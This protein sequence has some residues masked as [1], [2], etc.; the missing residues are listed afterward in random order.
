MKKR[1]SMKKNINKPLIF[2]AN[3]IFWFHVFWVLFILFGVLFR[4]HGILWDIHL[5]MSILILVGVVINE[6]PLTTIERWIRRKAGQ[7]NISNR[8][9][10]FLEV[11][12][13]YTKIKLP[14]SVMRILGFI[15]F[16]FGILAHLI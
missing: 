3:T 10:R 4:F 9:S 7:K 16:L 2:L 12:H 11:F 5:W 13:K 6:C 15:Y 1:N 8:G 14:N